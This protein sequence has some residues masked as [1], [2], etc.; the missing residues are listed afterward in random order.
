[1]KTTTT[2]AFLAATVSLVLLLSGLSATPARAQFFDQETKLTASD[3]AASDVFGR[4]VAISGNTALVGASG[5]DDDDDDTNSGSAYLFDITTGN[6]L[7]KLTASDAAALDFFGSS[8]AI[9]G[10]TALVGAFGDDDGGSRSGSAYLFDITTGNQLF[11]LTASDA[12]AFDLFGKSVAIS[13]NTALV[14]ANG[15][16]A[17][18]GSGSAYLFDI[19][20]GNQLAKLTASDAAALDF[21]GWQSAATRSWSGQLGT[22]TGATSP[23]RPICSTSPPATS[24]PS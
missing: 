2:F 14:G 6:Q 18:P 17:G 1:M 9:S 15:D 7:F 8:V 12:A 5:D 20:T 23:A 22:T 16:D 21:F 24:S 19:T 4:S 11:K 3:A 13:G 10:N